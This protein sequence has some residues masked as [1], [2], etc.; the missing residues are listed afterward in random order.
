VRYLI[1]S[2]VGLGTGVLAATLWV[3][4]RFVLPIAVPMLIA[5]LGLSQSGVGGGTGF[6]TSGSI[7]LA[8]LI[9]FV[10]GV[11]WWLQRG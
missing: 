1:A 8:A 5:R 3:L 9:G 4:V 2:L 11:A 7:M 6:V 10:A